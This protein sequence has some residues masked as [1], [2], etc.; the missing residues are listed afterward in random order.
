MGNELTERHNGSA[1]RESG[2]NDDEAQGLVENDR[3]QSPKPKQTNQKR[4]AELC[5]SESNKSAECADASPGAEYC[6]GIV[7]FG[8]RCEHYASLSRPT[9]SDVEQGGKTQRGCDASFQ[10]YDKFAITLST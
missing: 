8:T 9:R 6:Q 2:C 10:C 5:A 4:Q 1:E 3:F 7:L